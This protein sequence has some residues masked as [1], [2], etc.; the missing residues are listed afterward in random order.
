MKKILFSV[1]LFA[2][3]YTGIYANGGVIS[4]YSK[5]TFMIPM[6]DGVKLF[7]VVLLPKNCDRNVPVLIERTPYGADFPV[8]EDSSLSVKWMGSVRSMAE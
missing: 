4:D 8:K 5:K 7:T 6:R 2:L 1:L 3:W